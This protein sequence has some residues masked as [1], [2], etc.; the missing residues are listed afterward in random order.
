M[1][2]DVPTSFIEFALLNKSLRMSLISMSYSKS[3]IFV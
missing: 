1:E 3:D 2:K